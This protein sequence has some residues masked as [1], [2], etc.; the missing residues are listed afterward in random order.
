[1]PIV[2]YTNVEIQS[3]EGKIKISNCEIRP[4]MIQLGVYQRYRSKGQ[5]RINNHGIIVFQ[6]EGKILRGAEVTVFKEATLSI[7]NSFFIGENSLIF[8]AESVT[9]GKNSRIAFSS[10]VCDS[11]FHYMINV[12]DRTIRKRSKSIEI[13]DYNWIT[14][15]VS[16]KKGVKTPNYITVAA[17]SVLLKDYSKDIEPFSILAGNPAKVIATGYSRV[18]K[19]EKEKIKNL[20]Q[21]FA[22]HPD[23]NSYV[24]LENE[25]I[26]DYTF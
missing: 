12:K 15:N 3:L 9:I 1:M 14:N 24:L 18:W 19:D 4:L 20:N 23:E 7:G 25:Q 22:T 16:I 26:E 21:Y 8:A 17:N 6:G 13:G 5:T 11:D 10:I 2:A